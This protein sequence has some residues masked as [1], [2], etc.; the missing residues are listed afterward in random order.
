MSQFYMI[1]KIIRRIER[2]ITK[3]RYSIHYNSNPK[4][5]SLYWYDCG[6]S[7]FGDELNPYLI[8]KLTNKKINKVK[9]IPILYSNVKILV[10]VGSIISKAS[11]KTIVWGSGIIDSKHNINNSDFRAVRGPRTQNRLKELGYNV[12]E[13][14]GDPAM[15][16]PIIYNRKVDVKYEYGI[17]PHYTDFHLFENLNYPDNILLIDITNDV[18]KFIDDIR[19]CKRTVSTSL[20]GIIV[21]NTYNIKSA[22]ISVS[23][24][25]Y[26]DNIKYQ[27]YFESV[28]LF[29][30]KTEHIKPSEFI[31][32]ETL[33]QLNYIIPE[34]KIVKSIQE[35]LI[36]SFPFEVDNK[37]F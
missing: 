33:K 19:S 13:A 23:D 6:V 14:I 16:L 10:P 36:S 25:I 27:D 32:S 8:S 9:C 29:N 5:I 35:N 22:W 31:D 21:S 34:E 20:H 11:M 30:I 37:Y 17:I 24:K 18:E 26:G 15:L 7:N 2:I 4:S 3:L 1:N 28:N 12:P